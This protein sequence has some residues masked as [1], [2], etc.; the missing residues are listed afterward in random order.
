VVPKTCRSQIRW[1]ACA[2]AEKTDQL[3]FYVPPYAY[4][5]MQILEQAMSE[6]RSLDQ[7]KLAAFIHATAFDTAIGKVKF[8][9]N[10]E[11]EVGRILYVQYRNIAPSDLEQW[12]KPGHA[13]VLWPPELKSGD[14]VYP[15][16]SW[17]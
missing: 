12:K 15:Y 9:K 4:A 7:G 8:E 14:L 3:G 5:A 1:I 10:G 2:A 16:R 17:Q 11:W 13:V 6:V